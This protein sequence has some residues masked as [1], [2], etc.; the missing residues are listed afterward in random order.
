MIIAFDGVAPVA[1]LEQQRTR[2]HKSIMEKK[3]MEKIEG[4]KARW[5]KT[6]IT[7]GTHFMAKLNSFIK[8]YFKSAK[9]FGVE[10]IIV[11][12]SDERGEG[13]HKL[14]QYIRDNKNKHHKEY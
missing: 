10:N 7:P 12:G 8:G 9:K 1:K 13:E 4:K 2:R 3:I 6:A 11:S 5:N 14:F